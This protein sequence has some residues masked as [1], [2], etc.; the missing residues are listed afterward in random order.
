MQEMWIWSLSQEGPLLKEVTT[1]SSILAWKTPWTE[2]PGR[3]QSMGS[4]RSQTRLWLK[5]HIQ[6][7]QMTKKGES[8]WG[9]PLSLFIFFSLFLTV[10]FHS[11]FWIIQTTSL[12][13]QTLRLHDSGYPLVTHCA[14]MFYF[15]ICCSPN[16]WLFLL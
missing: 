16:T 11:L 13:L 7:R 8:I 12:T 5:Q 2:E 15:Y 9:W 14:L 10:Y 6:Q 1:H 3:P 4:Q